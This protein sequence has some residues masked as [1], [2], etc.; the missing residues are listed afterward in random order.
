MPTVAC[1]INSP[2]RIVG[3]ADKESAIE[4][5]LAKDPLPEFVQ[6]MPNPSLL[7][8]L[9]PSTPP[10]SPVEKSLEEST[11]L[12][13]NSQNKQL[14]PESGPCCFCIRQTPGSVG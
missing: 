6:E 12:E 3:G 14:L 7:S 9:I 4:K 13:E 8:P 11:Q 5:I 1:K 10:S 2:N